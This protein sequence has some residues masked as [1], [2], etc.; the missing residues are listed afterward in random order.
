M[1]DSS[2]PL[3]A[4]TLSYNTDFHLTKD[5]DI[6]I[7][8]DVASPSLGRA[9]RKPVHDGDHEA[10]LASGENSHLKSN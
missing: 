8:P 4:L 7:L 9:L 5:L 2:K 3:V 6:I 10:V 1:S